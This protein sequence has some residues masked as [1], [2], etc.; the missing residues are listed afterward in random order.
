M[1]R[2]DMLATLIAN[3]EDDQEEAARA[4]GYKILYS[5]CS[6]QE[7]QGDLLNEIAEGFPIMASAECWGVSDPIS[8]MIE[9]EGN[10]RHRE[11]H[12]FKKL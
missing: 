9:G 12:F 6:C 8:W 10:P 3:C 1:I 11:V 5:L 4:A 2:D 7:E